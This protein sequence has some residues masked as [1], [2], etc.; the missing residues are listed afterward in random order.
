ME[1]DVDGSGALAGGGGGGVYADTGR[2]VF[3]KRPA[4]GI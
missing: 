3:S 2:R 4:V 1:F